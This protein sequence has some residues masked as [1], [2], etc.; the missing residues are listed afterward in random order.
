MNIRDKQDDIFLKQ[1]GM[2]IK[3]LR[4]ERGIKQ[5]DLGYS[6]DLEKSNMSR[7]EAGNTNPSILIL[8]KICRELDVTLSELFQF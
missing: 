2:R 7:I 6:C 4:K 8:L 5:V 1:L 3:N